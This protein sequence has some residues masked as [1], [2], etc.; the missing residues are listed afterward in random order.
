MSNETK[1]FLD[2]T[3]DVCPLT[4][5]KTKLLLERTPP[6]EIITVRLKGAEPIANVPRAAAAHG[7]E[8]IALIPEG[9]G[10][11]PRDPHLLTIRR[12]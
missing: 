11:A 10:R 1:Y 8:V 12:K 6:G 5:V 3:L 2:I 9:E 4:F 7:H